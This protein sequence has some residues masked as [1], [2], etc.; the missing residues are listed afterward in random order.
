MARVQI[1]EGAIAGN[2]APERTV[3]SQPSTTVKQP[4]T[5]PSITPQPTE[6]AAAKKAA[7]I[8]ATQQ[9]VETTP[10]PKPAESTSG[11]PNPLSG[12]ERGYPVSN[13]PQG[14]SSDIKDTK[15]AP[16]LGTSGVQVLQA[17]LIAN[18]VPSEFANELI[19]LA[20]SI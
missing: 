6:P 10:A 14:T 19:K 2:V 5:E 13:L 16:G 20:L 3:I 17:I 7:K 12:G 8:D 1:D 15:G 11:L 18:G 4:T 9:T